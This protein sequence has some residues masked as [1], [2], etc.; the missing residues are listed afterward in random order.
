MD[1]IIFFKI[2][3]KTAVTAGK[4]DEHG[5]GFTQSMG[6][7]ER[8]Q[9]TIDI[10]S[11]VDDGTEITITF[12]AIAS[13]GWAATEINLKNDDVVLVL[14]DDRTI[15][16]AWDTRFKDRLDVTLKHFTLGE[17]ALSFINEFPNKD[18]LLLLVDF[19]L[20]KQ[21]LNGLHV[22]EGAKIERSL[23][24]T[25]H[26]NNLVVRH[27]AIKA[28]AKILPKQLASEVPIKIDGIMIEDRNTTKCIVTN[29]KKSWCKQQ[30][31]QQRVPKS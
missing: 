27:S 6:T 5:I 16:N 24:V 14:D 23:L 22:I 21:G 3:N 17:E 26:H 29:E 2:L 10:K 7:L 30:S 19:E 8:N 13:P 20:L 31:R 12:P 1:L 15:H 28:G 25:S 4:Q 18:Q 11:K 9:G